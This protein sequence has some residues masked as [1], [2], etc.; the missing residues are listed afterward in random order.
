V[1]LEE[2]RV[3][4]I[5]FLHKCTAPTL[6]VL[7]EDTKENRHVKSY[8]VGMR[9]KELSDGPWLQANLDPG[10]NMLI[11]V[12]GTNGAVV[13]GE[14]AAMFLSDGGTCSTT[15]RPTLVKV[16]GTELKRP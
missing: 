8:Q 4:D 2:L 5:A 10:S 12:S 9:D 11:P 14:Q 3:L 15:I 7:Y 16:T 1:R 13:I 6:A